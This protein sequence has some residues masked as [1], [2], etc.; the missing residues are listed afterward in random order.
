[1]LLSWQ[2]D[3]ARDL[4]CERF[5]CLTDAKLEAFDELQAQIQQFG[6]EFHTIS[7]PLPLVSLLSADQ[8]LV[9]IADGLIADRA[10]AAT[11]LSGKRGVLALP[12]T[13]GIEAGF[14][15]IDAQ[16]AW[17]GMFVARGQIGEQLAQMPEDSDTV[18]LLLRLALQSG[19]KLVSLNASYLEAGEWTL[20]RE[21]SELAERE[22]TLLDG[23]AERVSLWEP[24]K[25]LSRRI[26]R[27]LAPDGLDRGAAVGGAA[28][29]LGVVGAAIAGYLQAAPIALVLAA[30]SILAV[31]SRDG[32]LRLKVLLRGA[33]PKTARKFFSLLIDLLLVGIL[34]W[35][36]LSADA[37]TQLFL[38]VL[39]IGMLRLGE[40]LWAGPLSAFLADR[41]IFALFMAGMSTFGFADIAMAGI[42]L[43]ILA[44]SLYFQRD[45][46][47]TRA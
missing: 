17:G 35:P 5:I 39:A 10:R 34:A 16:H 14:E 15:R 36:L 42:S 21:G 12:D 4:G 37:M 32:M 28:S 7:G 20:L 43:V 38:P 30:L 6:G 24:T 26:A 11:L 19:V 8:E 3:L 47:I 1:M 2:V 18:S 22:Q 41:A 44:L 29:V 9:V 33:E 46:Q 45:S 27:F 25:A 40:K 31:E 23:S 13:A